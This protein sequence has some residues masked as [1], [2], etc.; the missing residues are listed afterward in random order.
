MSGKNVSEWTTE[1]FDEA[2]AKG[3][4]VVD[5]WAPWC[6]PCRAQGPIFEEVAAEFG[7]RAA[8]GKVNIDQDREIAVRF[9]VRSIPTLVL[10]KDGEVVE[11][12]VGLTRKAD[13]QALLGA[14]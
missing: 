10:L 6:G 8:F 12:R 2:T 5:F 7:D 14:Q 4:A 3:L 13:L 9:G 1:T 11:T